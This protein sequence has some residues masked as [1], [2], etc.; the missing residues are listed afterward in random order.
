MLISIP[1]ILHD[2][3]APIAHLPGMQ[4]L[5][6]LQPMLN[7]LF[8]DIHRFVQI[9]HLMIFRPKKSAYSFGKIS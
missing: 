1:G 6:V 2:L 8:G 3:N 5:F 9:K 4:N 7:G